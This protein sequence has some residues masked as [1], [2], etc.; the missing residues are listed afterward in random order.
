MNVRFTNGGHGYVLGLSTLWALLWGSVL[1]VFN[2]PA[3]DFK[4]IEVKRVLTVE[5][6]QCSPK[7]MTDGRKSPAAPAE[8]LKG[9][10]K[11]TYYWQS[12]P[13]AWAHRAWWV[14]DLVLSLRGIGWNWRPSAIPGPPSHVLADLEPK[15]FDEFIR[16]EQIHDR[17]NGTSLLKTSLY[18]VLWSYIASDAIKVLTMQ[19]EYFIGTLAA[20]YRWPFNAMGTLGSIFGKSYR[21]LVSG[22]GVYY[23]LQS[24]YVTTKLLT[25]T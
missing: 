10:K 2:D 1:L 12:F 9:M 8:V 3:R 24:G 19:D 17:K 14:A 13:D 4:R 11:K 15:K 5:E 22:A 18:E 23:A 25:V 20:P 7:L 6:K 16:G 21:L